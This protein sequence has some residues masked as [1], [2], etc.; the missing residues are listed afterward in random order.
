VD[1]G[2]ALVLTLLVGALIAFQPPANALLAR[3]VGDLGAA[4]S[5]LVISTLIVGVLLIAAGEVSQLGGLTGLR[6]EHTLGGVGGAAIVVV[7]I[8]AV[9]SLGAGGV[10]AAVV[11]TQLIAAAMIDRSGLLGVDEAPLTPA[12]IGG[13]ALLIAGTLLVTSG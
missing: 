3:H 1:K 13:I 12:R 4:F 10:A 6:P 7:T 11:A 8:A 2:V 5:S 9:R